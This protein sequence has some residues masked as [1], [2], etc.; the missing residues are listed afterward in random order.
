M[1]SGVYL[2][3]RAGGGTAPV[4]GVWSRERAQSQD[5][6]AEQRFGLVEDLEVVQ[7][8]SVG[9]LDLAA[10]AELQ[11]LLRLQLRRLLVVHAEQ[12]ATQL[13][14]RV[15]EGSAC[16]EARRASQCHLGGRHVFPAT[17][18]VFPDEELIEVELFREMNE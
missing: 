10:E 14:P 6:L 15:E 2:Q 17:R 5:V 1:P 3:R 18:M 8:V 16:D 7:R 9:W 11:D 12:R 13:D 4:G